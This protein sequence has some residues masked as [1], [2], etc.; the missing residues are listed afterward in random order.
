MQF[1]LFMGLL[2]FPRIIIY[3][4][5]YRKVFN[6]YF[7][8]EIQDTKALFELVDESRF[9]QKDMI[10]VKLSTLK[11]MRLQTYLGGLTGDWISCSISRCRTP[12]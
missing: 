6:G 4:S 7:P 9:L 1:P 11:L 5:M 12:S 10:E 2:K 3:S 8:K